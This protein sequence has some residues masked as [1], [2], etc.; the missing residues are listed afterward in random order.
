M[1]TDTVTRVAIVAYHLRPR[2]YDEATGTSTVDMLSA[3]YQR[4]LLP[5]ISLERQRCRYSFIPWFIR[6]LIHLQPMLV[7]QGSGWDGRG[8]CEDLRQ[9]SFMSVCVSSPLSW[10]IFLCPHYFHECFL[11]MRNNHESGDDVETL[12]KEKCFLAM[13]FCTCLRYEQ[14]FVVLFQF[15]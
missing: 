7:V 14:R 10:G 13:F 1:L 2:N 12:M 9:N 3:R 4:I 6:L 11:H 5:T 8:G 15:L